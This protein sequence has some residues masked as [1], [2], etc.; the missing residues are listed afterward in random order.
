MTAADR[1]LL[2]DRME[3]DSND[4]LAV[5]AAMVEALDTSVERVLRKVSELGI[6]R[7]TLI[8]FTSDNGGAYM[9][10]LKPLR[11]IKG[12]LFEAGVRVPACARWVGQIDAGKVCDTPISSVDFLPTFSHLAGV[13]LPT[14]QPVD[15]VNISPLL[16]GEKIKVR[17]LFWHYPLYLNGCGL[18]INTPQGVYSWRGFPATSMI[19]GKYKMINFLEDQSFALYDITQ[20][21]GEQNNLI[22]SMPEIASKLKQELLAWQKSVNAPILKFLT[23]IAYYHN[24]IITSSTN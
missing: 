10:Q 14:K 18:S 4:N 17:S 24:R 11:G 15:G 23:Q 12:S 16:R 7:N 6:D 1:K 19:R 9:S 8:I 3:D 22:Y 13:P 2:K 20:D 21:V 5:Y